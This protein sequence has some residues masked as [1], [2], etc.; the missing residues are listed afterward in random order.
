MRPSIAIGSV[1]FLGGA[2]LATV[3]LSGGQSET[4][5]AQEEPF[6]APVEVD[7]A[8]LEGPRQ[9]IFFRHDIHANQYEIPCQYCHSAVT[10]S[11]EPGI[12]SVETCVG[13]HRIVRGTRPEHQ[14]EIQKVNE[15]WANQQPTEWV[16][17]HKLPE[18]VHYPHMLH[19]KAL[20]A[21]PESCNTCHGP[22]QEMVQVYQYSSLK[23][24]WC[25]SCHTG[26]LDVPQEF[27]PVTTDCSTCHY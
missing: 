16:R 9:P 11:S 1:V 26:E 19:I 18:H 13:C 15:A 14:A 17:V 12:P 3:A 23:M 5:I 8:S 21:P 27:E 24:G 22:I 6:E 20:G 7:T 25:V 2:A 10:E 4:A